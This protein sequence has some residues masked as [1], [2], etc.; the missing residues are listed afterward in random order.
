MARVSRKAGSTPAVPTAATVTPRLRRASA[1]AWNCTQEDPQIPIVIQRSLDSRERQDEARKR[2]TLAGSAT[3]VCDVKTTATFFAF[4]R[5]PA[6][7]NVTDQL[8]PERTFLC[9]HKASNK[10]IGTREPL[11]KVSVFRNSSPFS[12]E[13]TFW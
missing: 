5:S 2:L 6:S 12:K 8:M 10:D 13:S 9:P 3:F 1:A 4:V 11:E 7:E